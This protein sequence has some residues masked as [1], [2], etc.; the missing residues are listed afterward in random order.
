MRFPVP[1]SRL[2][3]RLT[4]L[5]AL[6]LAASCAGPGGDPGGSDDGALHGEIVSY[7]MDFADHSETQHLLRL[8]GGDE[9]RLIL[10][11]DHDLVPGMRV[12]L[13]GTDQGD[14]IKVIRFEREADS[15]VAVPA[16]L[17][18]GT[19]KPARRWA[20]VL[21]DTG[22]GVNITNDMATDRLFGTTNPKSM[23][24]YY[25][26]DSFGLQ[27]LD[28]Q[29][30][31]PFKYQPATPCDSSG[32]AR[33]LRP[34]ITGT[35]DQYL[36]YFGSRQQC[37]WAGLASLGTSDRPQ[38][39]SWYNAS[40][41]CVVLAQEP[42]H[43]FGMVHSSSLA[44]TQGGAKVPL[45]LPGSG[46]CSHSEYGNSFDPMGSGCFHMDGFQKAYQDWLTGCNVVKV[47]T[48]GTFTIFPLEQACNGVQLLQIPFGAARTFMLTNGPA[49]SISNY[50]LELRAPVGLDAALTPRVF[51]TVGGNIAEARGRGGRNW[52]LDMNPDTQTKGD[53]ALPVGRRY[54]DPDPMGPKF[55]V[56]S[57]DATKAVVK[58]E[59]A[60]GDTSDAPGTGTCDDGTAFTAPGPD[61]CNA[62]PVSAP[63]GDGGAPPAKLD[64]STSRDSGGGTGGSGGGM[65]DTGGSNGENG[66]GAG[67]A[68]GK[69]DASIPAT[70]GTGGAPS[71]DDED[72]GTGAGKGQ[73]VRGSCGCRLGGRPDA[74]GTVLLSAVFA[75]LFLARRRSGRRR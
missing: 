66:S 43:N 52:L 72:A 61:T 45:A 55:T 68:A 70:T 64:G 73:S 36:W 30:F 53:A 29:V 71:T 15:V 14:A 32:A 5:S 33:T 40:S 65:G 3:Q 17:T 19:P 9:R 58:I 46:T 18:M 12:R 6:G 27:D 62:A 16:A 13:W 10:D 51:V 7:V 11:G 69:P 54:V 35:F 31:G 57:A 59:V 63:A 4:I 44:C 37:D 75:G 2:W 60:G 56:L 26:E 38:R 23:K 20:F 39:D 41:G 74:T 22:A 25:K 50:Y 42:G 8:P 21:I 28:G 1:T 34:K 48:S 67:G 24:S 47:T 49:A